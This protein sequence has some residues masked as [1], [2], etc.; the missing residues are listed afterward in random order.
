V[1]SIEFLPAT[2]QYLLFAGFVLA[3]AIKMPLF[4]FHTWQANAYSESPTAATML[5]GGLLSKMGVYGLIRLVLP[6]SPMGVKEYGLF[7]LTLGV[8]GLIYGSI[9]A[10]KENNL[11]RLLAYSSFAH[12]GLMAAGVLSGTLE[13]MQ[14]AMFQMMAHG[15]NTVGLFFVVKIIFE[16]TGVRS[17]ESLGGLS[18]DAPR[19]S[20]YFMIILLGSVALPLT[21]GFV[22]EFLLLKGVFDSH[23]LLGVIAGISIILGAVYMLRLFQKS[24]F[25]E[26]QDSGQTIKDVSGSESVV[27]LVISVLVLIMGV[28]PNYIL[29]MSE[30]ASVQLLE[31]LT[32]I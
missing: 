1:A 17:L 3:F 31:Y 9:V 20:I 2:A 8:V 19:L 25:G 30:P 27:L 23:T 14:G 7:V 10:V 32:Q 18:Q 12:I 28:F 16:R 4:P 29:K 15:V 11:K 24:M 26:K 22:G 21:N 5:L 13:G 6:F